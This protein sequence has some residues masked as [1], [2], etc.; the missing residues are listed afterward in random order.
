MPPGSANLHHLVPRSRGGRKTVWLHKICHDTIH[1]HLSESELARVYNTIP[2]LMDHPDIARFVAW[3]RK[4]PP[5]F[6]GYA[7]RIRRR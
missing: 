4:R 5:G 6:S 1:R 3:I 2:A 7:R